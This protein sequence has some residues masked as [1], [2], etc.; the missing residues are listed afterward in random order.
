[1]TTEKQREEQQQRRLL[2]KQRWKHLESGDNWAE[3][4]TTPHSKPPPAQQASPQATVD[5]AAAGVA[6]PPGPIDVD[7][8]R[9]FSAPA[10]ELDGGAEPLGRYVNIGRFYT[11]YV[12]T[13]LRPSPYGSSNVQSLTSSLLRFS[14]YSCFFMSFCITSLH[15][16][17][18]FPI[19]RRPI[20]ST[21][22][23]LI[24]L[25]SSLSLSTS[26]S[27]LSHFLSF[28][29]HLALISF[30]LIFSNLFI[31]IVHPNILVS[32]LAGKP[33]MFGLPQCADLS[34]IFIS[35]VHPNILVSVL[36]GKPYMFGLPQCAD[37]SPIFIS[38]IHPHILV[39]VLA[40]KPYMFGLP[41]C[42]DLSPIFISIVHSNILISVLAGKPYTFGLPQCADLSPIFDFHRSSKHS[43][44]CS[45]W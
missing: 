45:C 26:Q 6:S 20:T 36:A 19:F 17:G 9:S 24:A 4:F 41:Q 3:R 37:L 34:P 8:S 12:E 2:E 13:L 32:I 31:S 27:R 23:V 39:S 14:L 1:M 21:F 5:D 16:S 15:L 40:G 28:L 25:S 7:T 38:I 44:L 30:V 33:Y 35:I 11:R 18:D 43:R 10:V 29:S 42:A 22:H